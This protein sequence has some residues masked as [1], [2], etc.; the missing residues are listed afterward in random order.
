[1][2][3]IFVVCGLLTIFA[4]TVF[5]ACSKSSQTDEA[6]LS[7]K[8][9][10]LDSPKNTNNLSVDLS[11]LIDLKSEIAN[12][13]I[14]SGISKKIITKAIQT[15]DFSEI[16]K[17]IGMSDDEFNMYSNRLLDLKEEILQKYPNVK[18]EY[19]Q[20]KECKSCNVEKSVTYLSKIVD[21]SSL[22]QDI[23]TQVSLSSNTIDLPE[24]LSIIDENGGCC[25]WAK[26]TACLLVC[27]STG[28]WLYW[29][30]AGLCLDTYHCSL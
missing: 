20:N 21:N 15:Q 10:K 19:N 30:C 3:K 11:R 29:L 24:N 1:M 17:S 5:V 8:N 18:N 7:K 12:R 14:G 28:P 22:N 4:V 16:K 6:S 27:T 2:K 9:G 23:I 26:Y 13:I 25:C